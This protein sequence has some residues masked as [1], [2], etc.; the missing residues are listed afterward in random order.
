[1]G[2][3]NQTSGKTENWSVDK[4]IPA[5]LRYLVN[6]RVRAGQ[7][8]SQNRRNDLSEEDKE[9]FRQ[10]LSELYE[11]YF[12]KFELRKD[13]NRPNYAEKE[14]Y[15]SQIPVD[16]YDLNWQ[17]CI[18]LYYR[19][20]ELQEKLGHTTIASQEWEEGEGIGGKEFVNQQKEGGE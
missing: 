20:A 3:V 10:I 19:V 6:Q 7:L 12:N 18:A 14:N 16:V 11:L 13:V 2:E 9:V 15:G 5:Y 4:E 1:M 8:M 17:Q